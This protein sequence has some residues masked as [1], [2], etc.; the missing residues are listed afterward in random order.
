IQ[1]GSTLRRLFAIILLHGHPTK[2]EEL[3]D[4]F[5]AKMCDNL[6]HRLGNMEIYR[7]REFTEEQIYDFGL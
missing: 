5:K 3:W 6:R 7:N 1:T 4:G 2:P